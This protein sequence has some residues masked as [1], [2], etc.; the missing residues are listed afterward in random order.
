MPIFPPWIPPHSASCLEGTGPVLRLPFLSSRCLLVKAALPCTFPKLTT[1]QFLEGCP[2]P[3]E[4]RDSHPVQ[5]PL[6]HPDSQFAFQARVGAGVGGWCV[7][8]VTFPVPLGASFGQVTCCGQKYVNQRGVCHFGVEAFRAGVCD[9]PAQTSP[10]LWGP[11][12]HRGENRSASRGTEPPKLTPELGDAER[13]RSFQSAA[14]GVSV[15]TG[16]WKY[17]RRLKS[18]PKQKEMHLVSSGWD[19]SVC[20]SLP[21]APRSARALSS[22]GVWGR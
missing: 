14:P 13:Q 7:G 17:I 9:F 22:E 3:R 20:S 4:S 11:P 10:L 6:T 18:G 21:F 5:R 1:G 19:F 8:G 15:C 12:P 16:P 2:D